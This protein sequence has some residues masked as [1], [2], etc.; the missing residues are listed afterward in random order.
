LIAKTHPLVE[1]LDD[2]SKHAALIA[3]VLV[4]GT[5]LVP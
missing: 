2:V 4:Q 3:A 1:R 5:M